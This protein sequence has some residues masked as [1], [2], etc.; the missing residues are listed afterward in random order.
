MN[1]L[2]RLSTIFLFSLF[3]V[4]CSG[5]SPA[6]G[7][8]NSKD[9]GATGGEFQHMGVSELETYLTANQGKPTLMFFWTTWCPSCKQEIPEMEALAKSHGDSVN[10]IAVSLDEKVEA[11]ETFFEK[12]KIDLPVYIG[13]EE[14]ARQFG[15]EAIPTLVMFDKSGK[16]VFAKP[17]VFPH[18]MLKSMAEELAGK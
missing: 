16:Q 5:G 4:A 13:D 6:E 17:G 2:K 14:L 15:I 9:E 10:V 11:L 7:E 18:A 3:L 12:R 8:P 1:N